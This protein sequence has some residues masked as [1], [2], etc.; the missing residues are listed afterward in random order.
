[1]QKYVSVLS[2]HV[3]SV[4]VRYFMLGCSR[5][6]MLALALANPRVVPQNFQVPRIL[7][8]TYF[9]FVCIRGATL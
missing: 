5:G 3:S 9:S 4:A 2:V 8:T 6:E 7:N 1:M